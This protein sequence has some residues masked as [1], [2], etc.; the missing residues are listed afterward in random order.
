VHDYPL[1]ELGPRAFEQ[2]AVALS[3][4]VLGP[5]VEAFG[6][7]PDGGREATYRGRVNWSATSGFGSGSWDG[8]VVIQAKQREH[9]AGP[10]NNAIWLRRQIEAEFDRWMSDESKRGEFPQYIVFV[11]NV[12]LSSAAGT[13]GIDSLNEI[14]RERLHR[15][16]L[17]ER[18]ARGNL[19]RGRRESG[20]K[21]N[22]LRARGLRAWKIWHRDQINA[23]LNVEE[24]IRH[25]FPAMLTAGDILAR[26]EELSSVSNP[27]ELHSVLTAHA[28]KTLNTERWINFSEAGGSTRQSVEKVIVD[29]RVDGSVGQETTV[30]GEIIRRGD[31][32]LKASMIPTGEQRHVVL[33][34]SPGNG[35]STI[36]R[37]ITQVYRAR[38]MD[39]D[40]RTGAAE[41]IIDGTRAALDRLGLPAP[42]NRRWPIRVDLAE[43]ADDLGP[44][45]DKSLLRWLS[46]R[47]TLRAEID[48]KPA[49]LKRWLRRWPWLLIL[50][51]LD[52]VTSPEVRRRV[53]DEIESFVEEADQVDADLL[54]V[55]TT[56][57]TGYTERIAPGHFIQF[58]LR[59]FDGESAV[60]YG[61]LVTSRRLADDL[62]RR[63]LVLERFEKQATEP[64]MIRLMRT[65]LQ[66]LIMTFILER[67]GNLPPDRYQLFWRYY[68]T[69]YDRESAKN[70]TLASLL[71]QHRSS[72]TDLHEAVGIALQVRAETS[73]DASAL[74]P[75][76][77]L[78]SLAE[79]RMLDLGHEHGTAT[80]RLAD[81][82]VTASTQRLVLLV[83]AEHN[84][85]T[86]EVRSLEELMA[87]RA[88]SNGT[89]DE[90]RRRLHLAAPSPHWRNTW[91]FTAG[92]LCSEG[93]DHRR[94]LIAEV[95]ETVDKRPDWP[96]WLCPVGPGLA[97][98]LLDDGITATT[99]KWQRRLLDVALRSLSE[100]YPQDP[101]GLA[102][103]LTAAAAMGNN[104]MYIRGA[105]KTAL[106]GTPRSQ[107]V[108][109][110]I[111]TM[112]EFGSAIPGMPQP[113]TQLSGGS[114]LD[115]RRS[116]TV[117]EL[118]RPQLS[119]IEESPKTLTKVERALTELQGLKLRKKDGVLHPVSPNVTAQWPCT[120]EALR[121]RD[122]S[123]VI[124]L[125]CGDLD[126][127]LW[128]AQELLAQAV[129]PGLARVP[130]GQS[131]LSL[132]VDEA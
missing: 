61:R 103:G 32:V 52:E 76:H 96:A 6:S 82:I 89:D 87:A 107:T 5:G 65:P 73:T 8:Y 84:T 20:N 58:D 115:H 11:T 56:R 4:K 83:P 66:V 19:E 121:D 40:V 123:L 106:A 100:A 41:E 35:K 17:H 28:W 74:L 43:L 104:L 29:L 130:V 86:F 94:D 125:L 53:L 131:L 64:P 38:F 70:T 10:Q 99:P 36:S 1:E 117:A 57:P 114:P 23:L 122:A 27:Q 67:L 102:R 113:L 105:L 7:G 24:G 2:L 22:T 120:I 44:S 63:D 97:A 14:I 116:T 68:E 111:V 91:V 126:A 16:Y 109:M 12:R 71:I 25:A 30:L 59:Y 54:I 79:A 34:G 128:Q 129:W 46:E 31:T 93:P 60:E 33:T 108:A 90:V 13:G 101:R 98:D 124:W 132:A 3:L 92:R 62:D 119:E 127:D 95:V 69:V 45:G 112:G 48:I 110:K 85:V 9:Q 88:L 21:R 42:K 118:L 39:N 51:G 81:Q 72:I 80:S 37:F 15:I 47:V 75:M 18:F 26:L 50:D 49:T 78:R 77:E 55:V